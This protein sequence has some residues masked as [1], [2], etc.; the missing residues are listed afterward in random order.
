MMR[1]LT[2][3]LRDNRRGW[4][5]WA[6]ALAA[7]SAMY[8]SFYPTIGNNPQMQQAIEAYPPALREALHME[9]LSRPETYLGSTV[10]GLL[11]PILLAVMAIS[12]GMKAIAGDEEAGTLDLV[13]AQPVG[14]VSLALQRFGAI[15]VAVVVVAVAVGLTITGLRGPAQFPE[16]SVGNIAATVFQL[17]L[18]GM[19]FA[20]LTYA[21]GAWTGRKAVTLAVG[22]AVAVLGYLGNSFLPQIEGLK[23]TQEVSPFYWYL[24][25][26]PLVNGL[27]WAGIGLLAG[28]SAVLVALGTWRFSR[29]DIAV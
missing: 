23:W 2:K 10:F 4:I 6:A 14:R 26:Q 24:G 15:I 22:A 20:A 27:D 3:S 12:A 16:V 9:D 1:V 8:G 29:R 7:V 18:F 17:G 11:V 25:G 28:V 19:L 5:G 13:A 21:V